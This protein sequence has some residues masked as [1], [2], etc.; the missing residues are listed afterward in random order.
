METVEYIQNHWKLN[1]TLLI[2]GYFFKLDL[3]LSS[4]ILSSLLFSGCNVYFWTKRH[5]FPMHWIPHIQFSRTSYCEIS[6]STDFR[7]MA[8]DKIHNYKHWNYLINDIN[9]TGSV[10]YLPKIG[11]KRTKT[12]DDILYIFCFIARIKWG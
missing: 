11:R 9:D 5:I 2:E 3:I 1:E 8:I 4:T 6:A 10:K 12:D 7:H